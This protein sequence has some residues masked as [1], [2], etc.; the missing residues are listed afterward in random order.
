LPFELVRELLAAGDTLA[1]LR[2]LIAE[3]AGGL[4]KGAAE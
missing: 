4:L 1:D 2:C 3:P